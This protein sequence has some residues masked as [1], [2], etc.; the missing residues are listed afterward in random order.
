MMGIFARHDK[1]RD[2]R[3]KTHYSYK[4]ESRE[5][6]NN[7]WTLLK[8]SDWT[9]HVFLAVAS[10]CGGVGIVPTTQRKK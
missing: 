9:Q 6:P 4:H 2:I 5:N 8:L 7:V 10:S 1:G 3:S